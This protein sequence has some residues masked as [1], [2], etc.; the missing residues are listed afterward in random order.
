MNVLVSGSHG[1]IGSAVVERLRHAGHTVYQLVRQAISAP[2]ERRWRPG[3]QISALEGCEAVIHLAGARIDRRWTATA[4]KEIRESRVSLTAALSE[5]LATLPR[6]P[7]ALLCASGV[8]YYGTR[9]EPVDED[10]PAGE[11]MIAHL[12]TEWENAAAPARKAGV[13]VV[14]LRFGLVLTPRGGALARMLPAFRWGLGGPFGDGSQMMSWIHVEDTVEAIVHLLE[15]ENAA[16]PFNL[17]APA[18]VS[19]RCFAHALGRALRRPAILRTPAWILRLAFGKM[20]DELLLGGV[21]ALPRRLLQRGFPFRHADI[22]S[23]L[24]SLLC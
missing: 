9:R 20:A 10:S 13:R 1:L 11:G 21:A 15:H 17:T 23:A 19:N 2:D 7:R 16:G 3:D 24:R 8:G 18:P 12:V 4:R 5:A 14:H 22:E 6:P